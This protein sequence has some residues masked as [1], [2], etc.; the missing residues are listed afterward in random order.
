LS[1]SQITDATFTVIN[2][3]ELNIKLP[4]FFQTEALD[5]PSVLTNAGNSAEGATYISY[6]K[7]EN[8]TAQKFAKSYKDKF[9]KEP[10]LFA[11][12]GYDAVMLIAT[13]LKGKMNANTDTIKQSLYKIKN[14]EGSSG[15]LTF[16][17]NGDVE[18]PLA[19]KII[20]NGNRKTIQ[21]R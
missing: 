20:E 4:L 19:I 8:T 9:K 1:I 7:V 21:S 17:K 15:S 2:V 6:A 12:E 14:F 18:K 11:A 3:K 5:D 10:E 16:D 13:T